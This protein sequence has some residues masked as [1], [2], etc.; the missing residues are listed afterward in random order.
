[1]IDK[2]IRVLHTLGSLNP[3]GIETWLL[4]VL[5][6][7]D[8]D[9]F[10]FD[11]CV[12]GSESGLYEREVEELGARILRC[13]KANIWTFRRHFARILQEGRYDIVQCH[14]TLFS[15]AIL[16]W[17]DSGG[18]PTRIAHSHTS[19]D[20]KPSTPA[21][22]LYRALMKRWIQRYATHGLA[23]SQPAAAY[24][25]GDNWRKDPRFQVLYYGIDLPAF[26]GPV[27]REEVRRELGI[28][29]DARVVGHVGNFVPAKNHRFLLQIATEVLKKRPEVCFLLVGDGPLKPVI[30]AQ[31]SASGI[32]SRVHFTGRRTDVPRLLRGAIDAFIL[33]SIWEG[34]PV[35]LL[36]A[37]AAGLPCIASQ[38]ITNESSIL[39]ERLRYLPLS[40]G[41][42]QWAATTIEVLDCGRNQNDSALMAMGQSDFSIQRS[43]FLL[44][45]LYASAS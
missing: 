39:P 1:M 4:H 34:L 24:L 15:G 26:C 25:F 2:Q 27:S 7:I 3:G 19:Q 11:F 22:I 37:Q 8:R 33:P 10:Q 17:A 32:R 16:R 18:V 31:A 5:R 40:I 29:I 44:S 13:P 38:T 42:K 9:R 20:G 43:K 35:A 21:R 30:E 28:P 6:H 23:A 36:E 12:F 45:K 41:P 14:A